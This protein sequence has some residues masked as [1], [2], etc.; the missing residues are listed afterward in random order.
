MKYVRC[1]LCGDL[2][3]LLTEV[4]RRRLQLSS[5]WTR[6][7]DEPVPKLVFRKPPRGTS[8]RGRNAVRYPDVLAT[9]VDIEPTEA[10]PHSVQDSVGR[11]RS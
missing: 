9:D 5:H 7:V 2:R 10:S 6:E 11:T 4:I 3:P 1:Q 8:G